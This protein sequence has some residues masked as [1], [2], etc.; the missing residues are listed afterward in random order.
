MNLFEANDLDYWTKPDLNEIDIARDNI[1][2]VMWETKERIFVSFSAG[3]DSCLLGQLTLEAAEELKQTERVAFLMSLSNTESQAQMSWHNNHIFPAFKRSNVP[4]YKVAPSMFYNYFVQTLG[5]GIEC[6]SL[7]PTPMRCTGRWK[8]DVLNGA[9]RALGGGLFFTGRRIDESW[10]RAK[11][12]AI[13][14]EETKRDVIKNVK[15]VTLWEYLKQIKNFDFGLTY[16]ELADYYKERTRTGCW[17]CPFQLKKNAQKV[18]EP[19]LL[20]I[21]EFQE[22]WRE[23]R[24]YVLKTPFEYWGAS[25]KHYR[26][27]AEEKARLGIVDKNHGKSGF[28]P[29]ETREKLLN[30]LERHIKR[31]AP[32][33]DFILNDVHR[34]MIR[35]FWRVPE[36]F[37]DN[38]GA[39]CMT[40]NYWLTIK[41]SYKWKNPYLKEYI[42]KNPKEMTRLIRCVF[43]D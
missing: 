35:E 7:N 21:V 12:L 34:D 13:D 14:N 16:N 32:R 40:M 11:I 24:P 23:S 3:K 8:I 27:R 41:D 36:Q 15:T 19:A 43:L 5:R 42:F 2:K 9:K 37:Q 4:L 17:C 1:K 10:R 6:L 33:I 39:V 25:K 20:K 22:V 28:I 30:L 38:L 18:E 29:V 26:E 31:N